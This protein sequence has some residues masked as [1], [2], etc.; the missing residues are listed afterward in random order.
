[1]KFN[2]LLSL[3][4]CSFIFADGYGLSFDGV[5]DFA[6]FETPVTSYDE[7]LTV[8]GW[9]NKSTSLKIFAGQSIIDNVNMD[10]S[11]WLW[12]PQS[13]GITWYVNYG[14][15][16]KQVFC[17]G[18]YFNE[19][20]NHLA[21]TASATHIKVFVNGV[22]V[23]S[24]TASSSPIIVHEE[25]SIALG[26]DPRLEGSNRYQEF[27]IDEFRMWKR[28]L[29]ESEIYDH[30]NTTLIGN[31]E[32]LVAYFKFDEGSG[33]EISGSSS[34]GLSGSLIGGV[35]WVDDVPDLLDVSVNCI[36]ESAC[37]YNPYAIEDDGSCVF[38]ESDFCDCD[39]NPLPGFCDCSGETECPYS[40]SFDGFNDY[41]ETTLSD[42]SGSELTV[43]Y[44]FKGSN[45][46]SAVRIQNNGYF[47]SGWLYTWNSPAK[48][49]LSNDGGSG[50][51]ILVG[52]AATDGEWHH[53]AV[54]WKQNT[55]NGFVSYLDG[56][57]VEQRN[58]S[59]SPIPSHNS[60]LLL[61][62]YVA[63]NYENTTGNMDEIRIWSIS[64]SQEE[65]QSTMNTQLSGDED[66]LTAYWPIEYAH[67]NGDGPNF[68]DDFSG[69]DYD[70]VVYGCTWADPV[71][72]SEG[73]DDVSITG[74]TDENAENYDPEANED[75]GSCMCFMGDNNND[76]ATDIL[77][78]VIIIDFIIEA[79]SSINYNCADF[80]GD[81]N[82]NVLD[83][84]NIIDLILGNERVSYKEATQITL[85][86]SEHSVSLQSDGHVRGIQ[87]TLT[88]DSDFS[89]QMGASA[90]LSNYHIKENQTTLVILEPDGNLF[91]TNSEFQI[92]EVIAGG[93]QGEIKTQLVQEYSL[94]KAYPNPFN[95]VTTIDYHLPQDANISIAVFDLTGKQV[96]LLHEGFSNQG[97]HSL[98]WDASPFS[99]GVYFIHLVT[100]N[101]NGKAQRK[102]EN[103][104][105]ILL[106]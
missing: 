88:H 51:G 13:G 56:E 33:D 46:Q 1:M 95:P 17:H 14:G 59:N 4:L 60:N 62:K 24:A 19:G 96:A 100:E 50:D 29:S 71:P 74:C 106:K 76:G 89:I 42:I 69:N 38:P 40:L 75:D 58:S 65:I 84:I 32:D 15:G 91:T 81:G 6:L 101:E 9:I 66:G 98:Q 43:E 5:D 31:E 44:W 104:K 64:R 45:I 85:L 102:M 53:V 18:S 37:N 61:G 20:W 67:D 27:N 97:N 70:G 30:M 48:H 28:A 79:S 35:E 77:D 22:E 57:L 3:L 92:M 93:S 54:T 105:L 7:G 21:T 10:A 25:S 82:V 26:R 52:A 94:L 72:L 47:S 68:I 55:E 41:V 86:H 16:W 73:G 87:L 103:I 39:G 34:L 80:N 11:T 63:S 78:V 36:D 90:S 23:S 99:S 83:V 12:H 8:E 2:F 49:I